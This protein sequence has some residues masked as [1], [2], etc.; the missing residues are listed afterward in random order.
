MLTC[1]AELS[2]LLTCADW[3]L[4]AVLFRLDCAGDLS[5]LTLSLLTCHVSLSRLTSHVSLSRLSCLISLSL[6]PCVG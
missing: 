2:C 3:P 1:Q 6:L 4:L 5:R